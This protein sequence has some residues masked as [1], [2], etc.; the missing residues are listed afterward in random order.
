MRAYARAYGD[1]DLRTQLITEHAEMA[2]RIAMRV[3]R[4]VPSSYSSDDLVAAA[5]LGLTEAADRYDPTRQ[6]PFIGFAERRVRGAVLDELRRGD[7]LSRRMRSQARATGKAIR[8]LEHS[9]GRRAEDEEIAAAL[10][11]TLAHYHEEL[12]ATTQSSLLEFM[13]DPPLDTVC[14]DPSPAESAQRSQLRARLRGAVG[15]L[16]ERDALILNLYYVEELSYSEIGQVLGVTESRVCQLH[17]RALAR[18]RD[19]L[20]EE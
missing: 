3:A 15:D 18:L 12:Q 11:V 20:E 7:L 14:A 5:M 16:P 17:G 1:S 8:V 13:A 9:L 2:R 4:R 19:M 6:E 10:G